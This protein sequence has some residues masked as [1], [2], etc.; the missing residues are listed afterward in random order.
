MGCKGLNGKRGGSGEESRGS[1]RY[2]LFKRYINGWNFKKTSPKFSSE[3][4]HYVFQCVFLNCFFSQFH[5]F[6]YVYI[7]NIFIQI[8]FSLCCLFYTYIL[9]ELLLRLTFGKRSEIRNADRQHVRL[10][11]YVAMPMLNRLSDDF[12]HCVFPKI[13]KYI[14][15]LVPSVCVLG[16]YAALPCISVFAFHTARW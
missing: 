3:F 15:A 11:N 6:I 4:C 14:P 7:N 2:W 8:P 9:K 5:N 13:L 1:W 16:L 10:K 12:T